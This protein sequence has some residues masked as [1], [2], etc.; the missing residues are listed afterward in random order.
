VSVL[1][2]A[3]VELLVPPVVP[4][5]PLALPEA[6]PEEDELVLGRCVSAEAPP[7]A[8]ELMPEVV[9][10]VPD[11]LRFMLLLTFVLVLTEPELE[12]LLEGA[13]LVEPLE[14][15]LPEP[16][17]LA[18]TPLL[19]SVAEPID[20]PVEFEL[21]EGAPLRFTVPDRFVLVLTFV[22]ALTEFELLVL[23]AAP[24]LPEPPPPE[25]EPET[26]GETVVL[27]EAPADGVVETVR[28]VRVSDD[29]QAARAITAVPTSSAMLSFFIP[30]LLLTVTPGRLPA[31]PHKRRFRRFAHREVS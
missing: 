19:L 7:L 25:T 20:V 5:E 18:L 12:E 30:G 8:P 17:P 14:R 2:A 4:V 9:P 10:V 13:A 27:P 22:F 26:P 29:E 1:P 15:R 31:P 24:T 3:P 21:L 11:V 16:L 28:S 6:P 23:P